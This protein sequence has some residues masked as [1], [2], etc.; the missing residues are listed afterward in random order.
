MLTARGAGD[1]DLRIPNY[2]P[3]QTYLWLMGIRTIGA[4]MSRLMNEADFPKSLPAAIVS[5]AHHPNQRAIRSTLGELAKDVNE[6]EIVAPAV[7]VLGQVVTLAPSQG[8]EFDGMNTAASI[9]A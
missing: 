1:T 3:D 5:R 6:L 8:F 7:I 2:E 9:V 4:L